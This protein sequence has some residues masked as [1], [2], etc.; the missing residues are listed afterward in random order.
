MPRLD[1]LVDQQHQQAGGDEQV[2]NVGAHHDAPAIQAIGEHTRYEGQRRTGPVEENRDEAHRECRTSEL[3]DEVAQHDQFHAPGDLVDPPG[4]PQELKVPVLQDHQHRNVAHSHQGWPPH[5]TPGK[6]FRHYRRHQ[7]AGQLHARKRTIRRRTAAS[8]T[9]L[10]PERM[11]P[12]AATKPSASWGDGRI[13]TLVR[14]IC[15][16]GFRRGPRGGGTTPP[17]AGPAA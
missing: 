13:L 4:R 1:K 9:T 14:I 7:F 2:N 17:D 16:A 15:H 5:R 12:L 6:P 10:S 11:L 3:Q 8:Q